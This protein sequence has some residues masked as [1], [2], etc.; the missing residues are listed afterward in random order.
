[1]HSEVMIDN[2]RPGEK[3]EL[4]LRRHWL[5]YVILALYF[6][7]AVIGSV[8]IWAFFGLNPFFNLLIVTF[9]MGFV[10]FIYMEWLN[11]ELDMY[12]VTNNRIIGVE[13]VSFLNR[14][15]SECNLWQIQEVNS[16][17]RWLF[18]NILNYGTL[19]LQTAGRTT[20]FTMEYCPD[21]LNNARTILN[22]VDNFRDHD[23]TIR[24]EAAKKE[25][26]HE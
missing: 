12:V 7:S 17:S 10:L 14:V 26:S 4:V 19:T 22:V 6:I 3:I 24:R 25:A 9:W 5:V 1:M 8:M 2:L 15:V 23:S 21:V 16:S 11:H 13:Q 20:H 18:S